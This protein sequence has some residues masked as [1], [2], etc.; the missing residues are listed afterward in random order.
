MIGIT[1]ATG[2]LGRLVVNGLKG[3]VPASNIVA[4]VRTP[5]KAGDLGVAVREADYDRP[6]TLESALAGI[7][8][9]LLISSNEVGKRIDQHRNVIEAAK[10]AGVKSIVYTSLLHAD[11]S[12]LSVAD[13]PG[14]PAKLPNDNLLLYEADG[15]DFLIYARD[16]AALT[17]F[18]DTRFVFAFVGFDGSLLAIP[19]PTTVTLLGVGGLLLLA[20]A[21][22]RRR[23]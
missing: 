4:L 12:L 5:G 20:L 17:T 14:D 15:S 16:L 11:R 18:E 9:L 7:E 23:R 22:R 10:K 13:D 19:E 8:T 2:Q 3:R 1:G 6:E 21:R